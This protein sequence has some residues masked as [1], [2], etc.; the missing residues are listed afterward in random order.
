MSLFKKPKRNFRRREIEIQEDDIGSNEIEV[1]KPKARN[2]EKNGDSSTK[3]IKQTLLSFGEE[4][5]EGK[6]TFSF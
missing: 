6:L 3:L 4:L 5:D 1:I 2:T